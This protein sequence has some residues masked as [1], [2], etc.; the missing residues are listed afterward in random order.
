MNGIGEFNLALL[1][2]DRREQILAPE[3]FLNCLQRLFVERVGVNVQWLGTG[4]QTRVIEFDEKMAIRAADIDDRFVSQPF[5][6]KT[7]QRV[8]EKAGL[9]LR[10]EFWH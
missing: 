8:A 3:Y 1:V 6:E 10:Q 5:V 4:K 7:C 9:K 2:A